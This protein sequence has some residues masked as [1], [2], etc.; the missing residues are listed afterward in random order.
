MVVNAV[1]GEESEEVLSLGN[2]VFDKCESTDAKSGNAIYAH[3]ENK[4]AS[5]LLAGDTFWK[6]VTKTTG[7]GEFKAVDNE[8]KDIDIKASSSFPAWAL[9]LVIVLPI[10]F[11][12]IVV[13]VVITVCC[14]C[15][16]GGDSSKKYNA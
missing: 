16:R 11:V 3:A 9:V 6:E 1:P 2:I 7:K 5:D 10:V 8:D 13:A 14:C 4:D 15:C 12:L